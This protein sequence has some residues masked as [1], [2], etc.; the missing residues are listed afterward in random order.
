MNGLVTVLMTT[1][2]EE[3]EWIKAALDSLIHQTYKNIEIIVVVDN[4]NDVERI[5][6]LKLYEKRYKQFKLLIN[7]KNI[8]LASSLN[9]G[10]KLARGKYIARMDADDISEKNRIELQVKMLEKDLNLHLVTSSCTYINEDGII[11]GEQNR[12]NMD[13]SQV[14]KG[15]E[16]I[17][18]IVHPSWLMRREVFERL[19]GYREFECSQ[20]YD[21]LL[22]MIS[23]NFNI[24]VCESKLVQYRIRSNS[25]S[26]SK[27]FKQFLIAKYIKLLH[28]ERRRT[29]KDSFSLNNLNDFLI[30]ND[31]DTKNEV[32]NLSHKKFMSIREVNSRPEKILTLLQCVFISRYSRELLINSILFKLLTK[33]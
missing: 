23:C 4:P 2:N 24:S 8:G 9:K 26:S 19:D 33:R 18:F 7:E 10:F 16:F 30:A 32:Y 17:N 13:P 31:Y 1:Y 11:L 22:R 5:N 6:F 25:I 29:G 3:V 15:L 21:F 28:K 12:G 20:D 14:R 27:S